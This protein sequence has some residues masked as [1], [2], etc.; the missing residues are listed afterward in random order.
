MLIGCGK[1]GDPLEPVAP[2]PLPVQ[3]ITA[4][5]D[6]QGITLAWTPP[7]EYNTGKQLAPGDI[8]T[9]I[10]SRKTEAPVNKGW[11]FT[12]SNEGWSAVGKT[13][14]IKHHKGVLRTTSTQARLFVRSQDALALPAEQYRYIRLK[15]WSRNA[16]QGYIAFITDTDTTWNTDNSLEFYPAVHTSYYSYQNAFGAL[17]LK[18]FLINSPALDTAQDYVIDMSTVPTWKGSIKQIGILLQNEHPEVTEIEQNEQPEAAEIEQN[19]Q[20]E[21]TE[22]ELGLDRVEFMP[23]VAQPISSYQ[24]PPWLF[25]E[26]TEG[27]TS[28]QADHL[29]P[30]A[31]NGVLYAQGI[32]P[33]M[34]L[35]APG[36][37]IQVNAPL[38]A[39]I[40][41]QVTAGHIA[42]LWLQKNAD[43]K[44]PDFQNI[45]NVSSPAIPS[46]LIPIP[47]SKTSDF[48]VYTINIGELLLAE[49]IPTAMVSQIG[50]FF[51][52]ID[53]SQKRHIL[54]DYIDISSSIADAAPWTQ[55]ALPTPAEL[56]QWGQTRKIEQDPEFFIPYADLPAEEE[57]TPVTS[58]KLV[59]ISPKHPEPARL[60]EG[61]FFLK[62]TG[63]FL[64]EDTPAP[65]NYEDRYTYQIDVL[66]HNKQTN[67][68]SGTVT[69][70][71]FRIPQ[72]PQHLEATP[73]D[74]NVTLTWE[75]PIL[76]VDGYKIRQLNDYVIFRSL[77]AGVFPQTPLTRVPAN[78]TSFTDANLSNGVTYYYAIQSAASTT[79]EISV[80]DFSAQV[81]AV[82]VDNIA[83]D[84][85]EDV[86]GVYVGNVVKLY[87]SQTQPRDFGGFYIYRSE[88][89]ASGYTKITMQPVLTASY[90]DE[91]AEPRK[92]YYYQIT[93]IDNETPPNESQPSGVAIVDTLPLK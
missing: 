67:E 70:D 45:S 46:E 77:E 24:T 51:P 76:T 83:P 58:I 80:S 21:A 65:L 22:V 38:R 30:E 71:F 48:H 49:T 36:Q 57:T 64:V 3:G 55:Y 9:F 73:G 1:K 41:M 8:K 59:E 31:H 17:K 5:V 43:G 50:L 92:R 52:P 20:S 26:D 89:A 90:Q 29:L 47:L 93:A 85:P 78:T 25:L 28:P 69:V 88:T 91:T 32:M 75:R 19:A 82:P 53:V 87:W 62:D 37:T 56:E 13:T 44:I 72:N 81:S 7:T 11:R 84:A 2:L 4:S 60:E 39:Q 10:V 54:I 68:Q 66:D 12:T 15:L 18:S 63:E 27:W 33:I 14:P 34:L 40:R 74:E 16:R 35:S 42:Y 86:V 23:A 61:R 79:T 6:P